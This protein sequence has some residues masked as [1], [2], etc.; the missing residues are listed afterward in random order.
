MRDMQP[1]LSNDDPIE[2]VLVAKLAEVPSINRVSTVT[3]VLGSI[4]NDVAGMPE[5]E[6]Q[7]S[8]DKSKPSRLR[9]MWNGVC[10]LPSLLFCIASL[11]TLLAFLTAI[12]IVQL[13]AYGYLL[14]VAGRL[15][16]GSTLKEAL[17]GLRQA[18][19]IGLALVAIF[20]ASLFVHLLTHWE[21]V[22]TIIEPG[23][24][25]ARRLRV[26]AIVTSILSLLWL[27]WAWARGGR[28]YHYVWPEP[29]RLLRESWR[30]STWSSMPDRLW[31]LTASLELPRLFWLGF[32]GAIGTLVWLLPA[33]LII[34]ANRNGESA[35][36][37]L[38]GALSLMA[39]GLV[40]FYLP[41][42][43]AHYAAENRI[44]ALFEVKRIREDFRR[45]PWA[46]LGAMLLGL[47]IMP[48]PLYLLKIEATPQEV[49]WLPCL[50]FVAF[51]LPARIAQ[52]LALRR[53][54]W[55]TVP[56]GVWAGISRWL[57]R[58]L[59]V[60][61]VGTYLLFLYLSQYTSWDG[62]QTWVQQHAILVPVPFVGT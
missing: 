8:T 17:F 48:I 12:P 2:A 1:P 41:M 25:A 39:L 21:S 3:P 19:S 40:L 54:R 33:M 44:R 10:A 60:P 35:L 18:G 23:S 9:R 47:V 37:G 4:E 51:I 58:L 62:L 24:D 36:A 61:V 38:V 27:L 22:A 43:Q 45:A 5:R 26:G 28:W 53:A 32:R 42:L 49:V 14:D 11:V 16:A 59:M 52:G 50:V 56:S 15:T 34:A 29:K 31:E 6:T 30:V 7:P 55:A 46:W 13:I 20:A 57:V